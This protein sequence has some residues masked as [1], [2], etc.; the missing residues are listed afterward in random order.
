MQHQGRNGSL[1]PKSNKQQQTSSFPVG[2]GV[3]VKA[4]SSKPIVRTQPRRQ[5]QQIQHGEAPKHLL[6]KKDSLRARHGLLRKSSKTESKLKGRP[7]KKSSGLVSRI[8]QNQDQTPQNKKQSRTKKVHTE[9]K[10]K[11]GSKVA[12][13]RAS[14]DDLQQAEMVRIKSTICSIGYICQKFAFKPKHK[15]SKE[16]CLKMLE[17]IDE[18]TGK[19]DYRL[20]WSTPKKAFSIR[21]EL[22]KITRG[23]VD[24]PVLERNE[25]ILEKFTDE[26]N[27]QLESHCISFHFRA[28]SLDLVFKQAETAESLEK[29]VKFIRANGRL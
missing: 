17:N 16:I 25:S 15:K 6:V 14:N 8:N 19:K 4:K 28:R 21:N 29:L 11:V 22:T 7:V 13:R 20:C 1:K 5:T 10:K 9:V 2:G 3:A 26:G 24:A 27:S 23:F 18:K 12:N